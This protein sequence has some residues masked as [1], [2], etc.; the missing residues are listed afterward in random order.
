MKLFDYIK[1]KI[2]YILSIFMAC[3]LSITILCMLQPSGGPSVSILIGGLYLIGGFAPLIYEYLNKRTF[4]NRLITI[5]DSLD[6]K[7]L[8]AEITP[9]PG[10]IEG[11][12]LYDILRGCNKAMLE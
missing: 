9:S 6:R 1:D 7:N 5:Y 2:S 4:Y 8:I 3:I 11:S 12:I 10:F